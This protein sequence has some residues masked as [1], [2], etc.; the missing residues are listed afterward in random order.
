MQPLIT[1]R[2][3]GVLGKCKAKKGRDFSIDETATSKQ[4]Q[5]KSRA[6]KT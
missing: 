4:K 6:N 2:Y 1:V 5:F 3:K